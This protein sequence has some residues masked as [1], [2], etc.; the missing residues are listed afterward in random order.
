VLRRSFM[1]QICKAIACLVA[2]SGALLTNSDN[3]TPDYLL[4]G[5]SASTS[6]QLPNLKM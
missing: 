3:F 4:Y 2:R 6:S 5:F 1:P